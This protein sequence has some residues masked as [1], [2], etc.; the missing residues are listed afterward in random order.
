MIFKKKSLR[1]VIP[2]DPAKG[3]CYTELVHDDGSDDE[4]DCIYKITTQDQDW[5][6]PTADGRISWKRAGSCTSDS[7][8]EDEH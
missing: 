2:L 5:V 1:V 6:N 4:L 7:D 3:V 8:E